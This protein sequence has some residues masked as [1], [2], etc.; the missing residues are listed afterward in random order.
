MSGPMPMIAVPSVDEIRDFYVDTLGFSHQMAVVGK[1]G[2]LDFC[3]L[4]LGE[5]SLMFTRPDPEQEA[6]A[7]AGG[8]PAVELYLYVDDV[9]DYH[10]TLADRGVKAAEPLTDQWWG[11][12]TFVVTDPNGY[13][14][15]FVT[16]V[17]EAV[18]PPGMKIV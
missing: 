18:P 10:R 5:T 3:N 2:Q 17:G 16:K 14:L 15:W 6:A 13:R 12:R 9:D 11:D 4:T 8:R 1:D 7:A